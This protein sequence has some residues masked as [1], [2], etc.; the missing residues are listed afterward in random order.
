MAASGQ[1]F[2]AAAQLALSIAA[3][4]ETPVTN[5]LET[6]LGVVPDN[7]VI[8]ATVRLS[9]RLYAEERELTAVTAIDSF[10]FQRTQSRNFRLVWT[11]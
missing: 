6:L 4:P 3:L 5:D 8:D 1:F 10:A 9:S 11:S 7:A 2:G